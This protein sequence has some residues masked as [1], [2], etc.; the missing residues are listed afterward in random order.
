MAGIELLEEHL[1]EFSEF[2]QTIQEER[3][4]QEVEELIM[5]YH[6]QVEDP[7]EQLT[8]TQSLGYVDVTGVYDGRRHLVAHANRY[9]KLVS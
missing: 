3:A 4:Q 9:P 7:N 6:M 1:L 8:K 2:E 5:Y